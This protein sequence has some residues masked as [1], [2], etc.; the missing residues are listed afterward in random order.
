MSKYSLRYLMENDIDSM[1]SS[2]R[3]RITKD[4][5]VI[6]QGTSTIQDIVSARRS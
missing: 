5:V 1:G 6:P 2:T 3:L 4:V